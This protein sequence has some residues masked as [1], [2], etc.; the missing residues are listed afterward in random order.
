MRF[1]T[2]Y[3]LLAAGLAQAQQYL[4]NDLSFGTGAR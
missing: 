4:V 2:S 3:A 1:P